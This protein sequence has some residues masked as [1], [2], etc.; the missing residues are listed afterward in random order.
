MD[1][2]RPARLGAL[3]GLRFVAAAG[4]LLFHHGGPLVRG[5]PGW[6]AR[7]VLGGHVWVSLFFLLSGFVLAW[8]HP[9]PLAQPERRAFWAARAARLYPAY[10]LGFLLSA[11]FAL[12]RWRGEGP[13]GAAKAVIAALFC[14]LLAQA[15]VTPIARLWNP[16][17]WSTSA[18]AAF[19]AGFPFLTARLSRAS[20][21]GL[22]LAAGGAW[23]GGVAVACAAVALGGDA[24]IAG[25]RESPWIA[26]VKFHPLARGGEFVCGVSLGLLARRGYS[27]GRLGP[28]VAVA[29]IGAVL[30]TLAS[31]AAPDLLVHN[32]LLAPA[33]AGAILGLAEGRGL[34][35]R[36]L[37]SRALVALG[38]A[39][40][41]LY[42]LQDP[43]WRWVKALTGTADRPSTPRFALAFCAT[44][45]SVSLGV[46]RWIE[47]PLQRALRPVP[48]L[49]ER[50]GEPA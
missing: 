2:A 37:G 26:V 9:A 19:Y 39:S 50:R 27:L 16:P 31:G 40:F 33:F 14:L 20:R 35:A 18:A 6:L 45:V 24:A 21:R 7:I 4:I 3:T 34:L 48:R 41:A 36:A 5:A 46:A 32:G 28:L 13:S 43:L 29:G 17:G 42:A 8:N 22:A 47:R 12:E 15:W 38:D 23:L 30:L 10:L 1:D 25:G 49:R 11:P 44:A